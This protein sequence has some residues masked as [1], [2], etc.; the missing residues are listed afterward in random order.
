[1]T[2]S[3]RPTWPWHG[4]TALILLLIGLAIWYST[5]LISYEWRWN[6]VPQYFAY[7]AEEPQRADAVS[8]VEKIEDSGREAR[9][10]LVDDDGKQQVLNVAGDSLQFSENDDVGEGD[11]VGVQRHWAAGPLAW[12]LWTT[13]WI[14]FVS[15]AIGLAIGLFTGLCR[16]SKNPTL[17][18]LSTL[19]V[20]LVR[21]TPLLVQIF[22][23]YFFIGTVLNLSREF[24]GVA[25]LAL[26][27]GAYVAEIVRAGVQSIARGQDEAAR[28]LGLSAAQSMRHVILPQAFKRV[29]PPLAGQF[30]SL[31][32]DT[33]LVSVIAITEL[34]KS[35]REAITTSF[36]T[37]EIWFCV[38]ALYLVINLPLS[39]MAS[40]LE[41]RLGQ[42]D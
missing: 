8:R 39:H 37:F 5:S 23:F 9:V 3:K 31:V 1:M 12:G 11:V 17:H 34:T 6:R 25:A 16:L 32:K 27:T 40:R 10:T 15:G 35:G 36:S 13:L 14:S 28:S 4:L 41:R 30:I 38:A 42:S 2:R 7:Q 29:L 18:D 24:A 26:F 20:E 33:S 19:Y 22:I 21:G